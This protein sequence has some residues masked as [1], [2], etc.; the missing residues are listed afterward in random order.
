MA[1]TNLISKS[2]G[3]I[4]TESG[5]GEPNH[6]SPK[7]SLYTDKDVPK[8]YQNVDGGTT[9]LPFSTVAYGYGFFQGNTS[10][11]TISSQDGWVGVGINLTEG[12]SVGFSANTDTL[13]VLNGY[14]GNYEIN[15][16]ATIDFVAGTNGYEIGLSINGNP[17]ESGTYNGATI[18]T[19]Y[20]TQHIG[21]ETKTNLSGGTT[22]EFS[23][24]NITNTDNIIVKNAQLF[25]RK[26]D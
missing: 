10:Q 26:L 9:W 2:L 11:T 19:T 5:N 17:P 22:L 4:L 6:I 8:T 15:G 21:F 1:T 13:V 20:Q 23:V 7:G 3:D 16:E 12:D 14:D 24:R 25:V 18:D